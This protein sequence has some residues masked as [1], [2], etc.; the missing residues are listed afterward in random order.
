MYIEKMDELKPHFE[1]IARRY[2]HSEELKESYFRAQQALDQ[3]LG[4]LKSTDPK[5]SH[6]TNEE[7][8]A[9]AE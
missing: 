3:Q 1:P 5:H 2:Q 8:A 4:A 7:R 6:I 9:G